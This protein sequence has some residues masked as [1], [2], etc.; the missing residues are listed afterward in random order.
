MALRP[1][2]W[3]D[4]SLAEMDQEEWE[5]VCDGCGRCCLHKLQDEDSGELFFTDV[6]CHLLNLQSCQCKDYPRRRSEVPDCIQL[7]TKDIESFEW[8]PSTCGYRRLASG[9]DL[10]EWHHLVCGDH[11]AVH[12]A[13][14]SVRGRCVSER[15]VDDL[16]EHIVEWLR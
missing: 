6:A 12:R 16:E 10:P 8:L 7:T 2:F 14:V 1:G 13:G 15:Y 11:E 9:Q 5:A 3:R 4:T